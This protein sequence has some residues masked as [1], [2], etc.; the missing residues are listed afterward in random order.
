MTRDIVDG[1][2]SGI[3]KVNCAFESAKPSLERKILESTAV[4]AY[5]RPL[6]KEDDD[7][8]EKLVGLIFPPADLK[9]K[10]SDKT[11]GLSNRLAFF[12]IYEPKFPKVYVS[13]DV[14]AKKPKEILMYGLEHLDESPQKIMRNPS[15]SFYMTRKPLL[16]GGNMLYP[17]VDI[18][19]FQIKLAVSTSDIHSSIKKMSELS[20]KMLV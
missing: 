10:P 7:D 5:H 1:I 3:R 18:Y 9:R 14:F 15:G 2:V 13:V 8:I 11:P 20:R 19:I 6:I 16:S 17:D 12:E 4:V